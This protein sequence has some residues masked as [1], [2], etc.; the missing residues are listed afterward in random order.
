MEQAKL[1]YK[2]A[3]KKGSRINPRGEAIIAKDSFHS[4]LYSLNIIK[5]RWPEGEEAISTDNIIRNI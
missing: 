3:S 5:G 4:L 1:L 2:Y